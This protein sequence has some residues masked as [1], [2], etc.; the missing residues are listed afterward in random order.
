MPLIDEIRA[1]ALERLARA[2]FDANLTEPELKILRHSASSVDLPEPD[3]NAPRPEIRAEFLRWLA[4]DAEAATH[5]DPRGIRVWGTTVPGELDLDECRISARLVFRRCEFEGEI[6]LR[7]ARTRGFFAFDSALPG[8]RADRVLMD[9]P[10][11]LRR[12]QATGEIGLREAEIKGDL[13]CNGA[14]LTAQG[15]A[16]SADNARIGGSVFLQEGFECLGEV[17]LLGAKIAG[18]LD[19]DDAKLTAEGHA[20]SADGATIG[21]HVFLRTDSKLE[22]GFECSGEIRLLGA[23]IDGNLECDGAKLTAEGHAL[24]ADGATIGGSVFLRRGFECSGLIR[25]LGAE[26]ATDLDCSGAKLRAKGDALSADG[27]KIGFNV[28]LNKGF[29]CSGLVAF[30]GAEIKGDLTCVDST[31]RA[32]SCLNLTVGGDL[33]WYGIRNAGKTWLDLSAASIKN[34]RDDKESWPK[35]GNLVLDGLEYEELTLHKRPTPEEIEQ[36]AHPD[37]L[38]LDADERIEWIQRQGLSRS[39]EPQPWMQLR[40]LLEKKGDRKGA[41]HVLYRFRCLAADKSR[42]L[43]RWWKKIFAWIEENEFRIAWPIA[44]TLLIGTLIFN[45]A[46][47]QKA[48]TPTDAGAAG[49]ISAHYPKYQPF[50]YTLENS[51]PLVKFGMDNKWAPDPAP[52]FC[53]PWFPSVPW[54]Y[55]IS[56]YGVLVFTRW[57]LI[58]GGWFQASVL[59]AALAGRFKN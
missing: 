57:A 6:N 43:L 47:N 28:S 42:F 26:V 3:E 32:I 51:V 59:A 25:L 5:I 20:L 38:P 16:L 18:D 40:G 24:S 39:S 8:I 34:L 19:C 27:A 46:G 52:P 10:L 29:E 4:T 41:K 56:T 13:N 23:E 1:Q 35:E 14:K 11:F 55:F 44:A 9:G 2:R 49:S 54:L 50:I 37:E 30:T 48:M 58:V 33:I 17:R 12:T 15:R 45:W 53:Q 36:Q 22:K 31:I 7:S 21:G